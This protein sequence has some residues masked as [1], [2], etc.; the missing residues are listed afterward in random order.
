MGS[1]GPDLALLHDGRPASAP[2][3]AAQETLAC[4]KPSPCSAPT[5]GNGICTL[6]AAQT[7][8][9]L[10]PRVPSVVLTS[11]PLCQQILKLH[12]ESDHFP[13]LPRLLLLVQAPPLKPG[14]L[15]KS[16]PPPPAACSP[17][18]GFR[19]ELSILFSKHPHGPV[20]LKIKHDIIALLH[21]QGPPAPPSPSWTTFP[22]SL[23]CSHQ[24]HC[25][26]RAF[27]LPVL[28][29]WDALLSWALVLVPCRSLLK[30][31]LLRDLL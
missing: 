10:V 16:P 20:S 19:L 13:R 7:P 8:K 21:P 23:P 1:S 6:P 26:L 4:R 28:S 18:R 5:P 3:H 14:L 25:S 11:H 27:A 15:P 22:A 24:A 12:P 30:C 17:H 29:A 9:P 31:L 2:A